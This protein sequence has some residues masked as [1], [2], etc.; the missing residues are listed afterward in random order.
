VLALDLGEDQTHGIAVV[1]SSEAY[2][3]EDQLAGAGDGLGEGV[4]DEP[5]AG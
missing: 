2:L 4:D 5:V 1:A 3:G